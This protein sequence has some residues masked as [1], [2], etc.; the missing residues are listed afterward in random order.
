MWRRAP[1]KFRYRWDPR[2]PDGE[3]AHRRRERF[4]LVRGGTILLVGVA[5]IMLPGP[6]LIPI[7]LGLAIL[8]TEFVWARWLLSWLKE[9]AHRAASAVKGRAGESGRQGR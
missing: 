8:A 4:R 5:M 6:A 3:Y 7:P 9:Q 2:P 1:G